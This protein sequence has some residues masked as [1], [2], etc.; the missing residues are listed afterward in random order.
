MSH[1]QKILRSIKTRQWSEAEKLI[2][3]YQ[4]TIDELQEDLI[5]PRNGNN[6]L[7]L[8]LSLGAPRLWIEKLLPYWPIN[9]ENAHGLTPLSVFIINLVQYTDEEA[10]LM[11]SLLLDSGA[12]PMHLSQNHRG[13]N[14]F[15]F[16]FAHFY[17]APD[18]IILL[19]KERGATLS[20]IKQ[21]Y[22]KKVF[23]Y[24]PDEGGRS[25]KS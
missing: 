17:D 16:L 24:R 14:W 23:E 9:G 13:E 1:I 20:K 10:Q 5:D 21:M 19:M 7:H 15:P 6:L 22:H 2:H 8:G 4:L 12:D 25:V 11:M 3:D 18:H